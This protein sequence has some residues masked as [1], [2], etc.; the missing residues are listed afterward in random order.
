MV[1]CADK[2]YLK[3]FAGQTVPTG[4][5]ISN[6]LAMSCICQTDRKGNDCF[7]TYFDIN[8]GIAAYSA[9][10]IMAS[11]AKLIGKFTRP[12]VSWKPTPGW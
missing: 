4:L 3:Y 8:A 11:D 1:K 10:T 2:C 5:E 7:A 9:Y 6:P 12:A